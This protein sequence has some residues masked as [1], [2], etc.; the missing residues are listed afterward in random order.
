[1]S[2]PHI[3]SMAIGMVFV[4]AVDLSQEEDVWFLYLHL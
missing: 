4:L 2:K 1:V 3:D